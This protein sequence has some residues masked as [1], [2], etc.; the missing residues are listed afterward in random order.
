MASSVFIEL[1]LTWQGD[2]IFLIIQLRSEIFLFK[3]QM[4]LHKHHQILEVFPHQRVPGEPYRSY[5]FPH[6]TLF[7]RGDREYAVVAVVGGPHPVGIE[8]EQVVQEA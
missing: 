1:P 4:L 6:Q 2:I 8:A 3:R 5:A 7:E